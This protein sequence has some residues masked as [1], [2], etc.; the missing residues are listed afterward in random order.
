MSIRKT[1]GL[2]ALATLALIALGATT[3]SAT[4]TLEPAGAVPTGTHIVNGASD[5]ATL[6][7]TGLGTLTCN[8][9]STDITLSSNGNPTASGTLNSL[10]FTTCTDT[11]PVIN[12]GECTLTTSPLPIVSITGTGPTGGF[13]A[14]GD[15]K[16][17]CVLV[18]VGTPTGSGCDYTMATAS[19]SVTNSPSKALFNGISAGHVSGGSNDLGSTLCG[20]GATF[21]TTLTSLRTAAGVRVTLHN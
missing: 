9:T 16:V 14:V 2:G 3:S 10:T 6:T 21:S 19:A 8:T 11:I 4:I 15:T 13:F 12:L 20:T 18:G 7:V 1:L 17:R 5:P